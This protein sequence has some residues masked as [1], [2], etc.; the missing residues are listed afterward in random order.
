[1]KAGRFLSGWTMAALLLVVMIIAGGVFIWVKN[2]HSHAI[3]ISLM[4]DREV[5]GNIYIGGEVNNPGWYPL[6]SGD[7]IVDVIKAAGGFKDGADTSKVTLTLGSADE[8]ETPQKI[9]INRAEAWL[10][11]A[12]P[13]VGEVKA[14]AIVEYRQKNGPF[15]DINELGKVTG[16]GENNLEKIK[17]L[18]TVND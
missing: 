6:F 3:E 16:F 15:Q 17:D 9:N 13:G 14:L 11:Q 2:S 1:M 5:E 4:P 10:L 7:G 18:I 8:G 12:L